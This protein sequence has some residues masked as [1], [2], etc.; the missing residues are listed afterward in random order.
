MIALVLG[1]FAGAVLILI[2]GYNPIQVFRAMINGAFGNNAGQSYL[3]TY[4]ATL[5]LS[6]LAFILPGKAGIWN[7]G[8]QGQIY[9]GGITAALVALFVPMPIVLWPLVTFIA[10]GLAG[11]LWAF[12]PGVLE[13]YRKA[14]AIVTTIML[15]YVAQATASYILFSVIGSLRP[16]TLISN[17]TPLFSDLVTLPRIPGYSASVMIFISIAIAVASWY[18]LQR[19]SLGYKMRATGSGPMSAQ[20]KGIDPKK[21]Q[22]T[23]MVIGGLIAGVAGAGDILSRGNY[24]DQFPEG[25][26]GGEGFAG[27]AVALVAANNPIGSIF[28]A[29]L[30]AVMVSG[31]PFMQAQGLPR[32]LVWAMQGLI[33]LFTAMPYLS[34]TILKRVKRKKWT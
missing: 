22:V 34:Q 11:A 12:V 33:I 30:F 3:L 23:A 26:F 8:A 24:V 13:P 32:E 28:S 15:N 29:I 5:I 27:I 10:S 16:Q 21:M 18:F 2:A 20:A 25:W 14:S 1:L 19:T 4:M 7:V 9:F 6:A 17:Q 31:A